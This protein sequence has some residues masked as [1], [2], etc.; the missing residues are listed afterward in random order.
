MCLAGNGQEG[1]PRAKRMGWTMSCI[2]LCRHSCVK[3]LRILSKIHDGTGAV[4]S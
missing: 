2:T 1:R 3:G 4:E